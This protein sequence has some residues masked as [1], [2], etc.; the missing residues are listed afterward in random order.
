[1]VDYVTIA[2][3]QPRTES[4]YCRLT[5]SY[6]EESHSDSSHRQVAGSLESRV[7]GD[8]ARHGAITCGAGMQNAPMRGPRYPS[9]GLGRHKRTN[10]PTGNRLALSSTYFQNKI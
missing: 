9:L 6:G 2:E 8:E 5:E 3:L 1:M 4:H 10:S 7:E